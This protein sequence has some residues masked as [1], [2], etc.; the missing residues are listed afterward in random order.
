MA[1]GMINV[2][3]IVDTTSIM[4]QGGN[5]WY[6]V[7]DDSSSSG[8]SS[9]SLNTSCSAGDTLYF[10]VTPAVEGK[11]VAITAVGAGPTG[12]YVFGFNQPVP[13]A[14]P[15]GL[16]SWQTQNQANGS[17]ALHVLVEGTRSVILNGYVTAG[18]P[19]LMTREESKAGDRVETPTYASAPKNSSASKNGGGKPDLVH[20]MI[21][22]VIAADTQAILAGAQ[23]GQGNGPVYMVDNNPLVSQNEG[24]Y[25][26]NTG[27]NAG[28]TLRWHIVPINGTDT[29]TIT[30]FEQSQGNVFGPNSPVPSGDEFTWRTANQ[31]SETYQIRI[32]VNGVFEF[33]W[34]PFITVN[35]PQMASKGQKTPEASTVLA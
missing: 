9:Q 10:R 14:T 26:L 8:E 30:G 35:A 25:E 20:N 19:S 27:C 7:D 31:G 17:Y 29:V 3:A 18:P 28:D 12:A 2:L 24:S 11:L 32:L 34:D 4:S 13:P 5:T 22:I 21:D 15:G 33:N 1:T 16:W 23:C 6:L